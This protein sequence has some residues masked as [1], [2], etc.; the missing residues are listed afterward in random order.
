MFWT[1]SI[2]DPK[3]QI[4]QGDAYAVVGADAGEKFFYFVQCFG[5]GSGFRGVL[6]PDPGL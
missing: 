5:S 3:T 6:D 4:I 2:A 1:V